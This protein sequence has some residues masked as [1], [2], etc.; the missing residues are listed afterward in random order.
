[1]GCNCNNNKKYTLS[2][3]FHAILDLTF[4]YCEDEDQ[5]LALIAQQINAKAFQVMK[6][7][8]RGGCNCGATK[9]D[10]PCGE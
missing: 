1:M 7:I 9:C 5:D 2:G 3:D 10:G 6:M 4:K 8:Q